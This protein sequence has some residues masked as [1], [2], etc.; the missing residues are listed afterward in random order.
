AEALFGT[1]F[2]VVEHVA[3]LA[4]GL[5]RFALQEAVDGLPQLV[6]VDAFEQVIQRAEP[7]GLDGELVVGRDEDE[8]RLPGSQA[9]E[10]VEAVHLGHDD[11]EEE[12]VGPVALQYEQGLAR[13]ARLAYFRNFRDVLAE[14]LRQ[15]IPGFGLV[16]YDQGLQHRLLFWVSENYG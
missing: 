8:S 16:V 12:Q 4:L 11:V 7:D 15:H 5:W 10:Q 9:A 14:Q 13:T 1:G 6:G 2:Q 3:E